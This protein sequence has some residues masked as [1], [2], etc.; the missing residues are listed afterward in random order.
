MRAGGCVSLHGGDRGRKAAG[1]RGSESGGGAA[2]GPENGV[3]GAAARAGVRSGEG[4]TSRGSQAA[5]RRDGMGGARNAATRAGGR[6]GQ[7][8]ES[9]RGS[10]AARDGMGDARGARAGVRSARTRL[11][12]RRTL[13]CCKAGGEGGGGSTAGGVHDRGLERGVRSAA[14][15]ADRESQLRGERVG[16][17]LRATRTMPAFG[18]FDRR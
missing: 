7:L 11:R 17:A 1:D 12:E 6:P 5:R 4:E 14:V 8:R 16:A 13:C 18:Q 2:R 10:E 15:R 9:G 3:R